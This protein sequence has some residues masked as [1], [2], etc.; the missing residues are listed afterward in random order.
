MFAVGCYE[1]TDV[2]RPGCGDS[3]C[4]EADASQTAATS[5][6]G[7]RD[8]LGLLIARGPNL[9][10]AAGPGERTLFTDPCASDLGFPEGAASGLVL[11]RK[12][13]ATARGATVVPIHAI[14]CMERF[15]IGDA[16][17]QKHSLPDSRTHLHYDARSAREP[18]AV[19]R[20]RA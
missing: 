16:L 8:A 11:S 3:T 12:H 19:I 2:R 4:A 1:S 7:R 5:A 13:V 20:R 9:I 17:H 10:D 14:A 18:G 6:A 15:V